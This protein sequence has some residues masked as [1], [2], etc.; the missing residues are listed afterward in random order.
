MKDR[1]IKI[2]SHDLRIKFDWEITTLRSWGY[3]NHAQA[4]MRIAKDLSDTRRARVLLGQ[5]LDYINI[6]LEA[7]VDATGIRVITVGLWSFMVENGIWANHLLSLVHGKP[8]SYEA[9]FKPDRV[10]ILDVD[11]DVHVVE[12]NV[13]DIQSY[14]HVRFDTGTVTLVTELSSKQRVS[15]F[16][17]EILH[18]ILL[19]LGQDI[20]EQQMVAIETGLFTFF[21]DNKF[22]LSALDGWLV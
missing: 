2:L 7:G 5:V 19:D 9:P 10:R 6:T 13:G 1:T 12:G 14:G 8:I 4:E 15:T 17:H 21:V 3:M 22:D 20:T 16:V 11:Y 18:L